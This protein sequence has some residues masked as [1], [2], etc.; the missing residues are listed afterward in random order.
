MRRLI[1]IILAISVILIAPGMSQDRKSAVPEW[2]F[3]GERLPTH[4]KLGDARPKY[5]DIECEKWPDTLYAK[6]IKLNPGFRPFAGVANW[7]EKWRRSLVLN[8]DNDFNT[9]NHCIYTQTP[10]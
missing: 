2:E 9:I 6:Y 4:D 8:S 10:E 3:T 1:G 5:S 7:R